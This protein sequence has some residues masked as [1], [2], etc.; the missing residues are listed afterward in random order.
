MDF[1]VSPSKI[2]DAKVTVPGD[3]SV[4]HRALM[5]GSIASGRTEVSGF[6][7][8]ED[9]LATLA[10][11][12]TL[13]V[14]IEQPEP[15]Q[16]SIDGTGL[17][18]LSAPAADLDLGNSGTAMR[19]MAGLLCGQSFDST[20]TGDASLTGR[21]MGRVIRPLGDMG[22]LIDSN[23]GR[24]PLQVHGGRRLCAID[25]D[26]PVASAQVKSAVLLAGLY[27]D[28]TTCVT[29]P[30]VTR[31]HTERMLASMGVEV[32]TDGNRICVRGGQ[33]LRGCRVQ[34]PADLSSASFV[35]LAALLA[36]N[37][38]VLITNVGV[39]PTRTGVIE[40]LQGMGADI[41]LENPKLLGAEPVADIRIR[42]SNLQGG[43]VDP[44]L[45]SLAIDEFPALFVAAA[46]ADG[47]TVF[48]GIGE[49]RVKESDRIAAMAA[50]MRE[51]GIRVD[52]SPDGA[53]VHGGR[54]TGGTVDSFCDHRVAMSLAV[55]ATIAG[56]E[57]VIRDVEPVD[58]SFPGFTD[59]M[60]ALGV[61]IEVLQDV[62]V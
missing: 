43:A 19:L 15:T 45:V 36:E 49:L 44:A 54:F 11:M 16:M 41:R 42:S 61:D 25:Y 39:N 50:G 57:V 9:C 59:C 46:S 52:E 24:P 8:G 28:G 3:K 17:H 56:D 47:E 7:A 33:A 53:I 14:G 62:P 1:R 22:A 2:A 31:D 40:I 5:L 26:L 30:A 23:D 58:T 55:A 35:M 60:T 20:L 6:L 32:R 13:G 38:D 10:A 48:S 18:G 4:S 37:A 34:V 12:R 27:A 21:P 51:L 29:E